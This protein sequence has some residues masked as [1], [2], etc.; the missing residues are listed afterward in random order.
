M[1]RLAFIVSVALCDVVNGLTVTVTGATGFTGSQVYLALKAQ[2]ITVHGLVRNVTKARAVLKCDKCDESEGI[3]I[4]DVTK[5]ES[6]KAVMTGAD[7]LV[8]ATGPAFKCLK[9]YYGCHFLK[10]AEPKTMSWE[11]V[12][13]QVSVFAASQG[14]ARSDR[15]VI[16]VSNDLTTVPEY[17]QKNDNSQRCF[18]A[19]NGEAFTMSSGVP[20][21]VIKPNGLKDGEPGQKEI[22]V[23]HDDALK[24]R[25]ERSVLLTRSDVVRLLV[26][27]VTNRA[28]TVGLRFDVTTKQFFGTPTK[29]VSTVFAAAM[30]PWDRR[31]STNALVV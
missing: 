16:L 24:G 20:F 29:D 25:S 1:L 27:A 7:T 10:G 31:K 30:Y 13:N 6:L 5:P 14:P 15:H 3:F 28:K 17:F 26:Y 22:L 11:A 9:N 21:T 4:G 23:G 18:Y 12:K 8:I 19:L 2:N